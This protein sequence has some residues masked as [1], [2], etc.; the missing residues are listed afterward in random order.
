MK[1]DALHSTISR[2][3]RIVDPASCATS[4]S[5]FEDL[6]VQPR[7]SRT[8][9]TQNRRLVDQLQSQTRFDAFRAFCGPAAYQVPGSQA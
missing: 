8:P 3:K 9:V 5:Q 6:L 7:R 4:A 2:V 1:T